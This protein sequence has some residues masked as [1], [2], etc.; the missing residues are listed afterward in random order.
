MRV[1]EIRDLEEG[2]RYLLEGIRLA[3][4]VPPPQKAAIVDQAL[5]WAAWLVAGGVPLPPMSF[6]LDVGQIASGRFWSGRQ[7]GA[8]SDFGPDKRLVQAYEDRLLARLPLDPAFDRAASAIA[9]Y[10]EA[11][12]PKAIA[13]LLKQLAAHLELGGAHLSLEAI[14]R[15]Q[16]RVE[17]MDLS[18]ILG[19][20]QYDH[21][22]QLMSELYTDLIQSLRRVPLLLPWEDVAALEDR[23][24]LGGMAQFIALRQIRQ[25]VSL[26][27]KAIKPRPLRSRERR[28]N[29][30]TRLLQEDQYPVGG[31]A[32]I[33]TR[34]S[35]ESLLHS[36]LVYMEREKPDLF[37]IKFL[38]NELLY[39][40][41]DENNFIIN[42][43]VYVFIIDYIIN[44]R[45]KDFELPYERIILLLSWIVT[46]IQWL[47]E[48]LTDEAINFEIR[49]IKHNSPHKYIKD[50]SSSEERWEEQGWLELLLR[51]WIERGAARVSVT[52]SLD[53]VVGELK[54][55]S[56]RADVYCLYMTS[57]EQAEKQKKEEELSK[58]QGIM[59]TSMWMDGPYPCIS[60]DQE[61]T[62]RDDIKP[63][64]AW[65]QALNRLLEQWI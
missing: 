26:W 18:Q 51:D 20:Y 10:P 12:R 1:Q 15:L 61:Q 6:V 56:H 39:Y 63:M 22:S 14:R 9:R 11:E 64:V 32:S 4:V 55:W 36:Q 65:S 59:F 27:E 28:K 17:Q 35:M 46:I 29:W 25:L 3:R 54:Q 37:D 34:G 16:A 50:T 62:K 57:K 30:T 33:A 5:D 24:A 19:E 42:R 40:S 53:S 31:F 2:V 21:M 8:G 45:F 43:R 44:L 48:R 7:R 41:R 52:D 23:S 58:V 60:M 47:N 38:R 49:F 13:F